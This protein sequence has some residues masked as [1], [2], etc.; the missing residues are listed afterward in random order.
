MD[1]D[2]SG[3][4]ILTPDECRGLLAGTETGR[5]ALHIG[6]LPI[7]VPV[8]FAPLDETVVIGGLTDEW[9]HAATQ[10]SVVAFEADDIDAATGSR[11]SVV[12]VGVATE[13]A[14]V[15]PEQADGLRAGL[16]R[17]ADPAARK[18]VQLTI[19]LLSGRR[20]RQPIPLAEPAGWHAA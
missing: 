14:G 1:I 16:A 20:A 18:L 4:E 7:I 17:W 15:P 13:L 19:H 11:W 8:G 2:P 9:Y 3:Y 5:L 12:I 10:D 6:T